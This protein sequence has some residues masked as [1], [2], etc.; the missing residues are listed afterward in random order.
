M[1]K[2]FAQLKWFFIIE[3]K[4]Y[5]SSVIILIS[6][7]IL[8]LIPPWLIGNIIDKVISEKYEKIEILIYIFSIVFVAL[9]IYILRCMWRIL[10]F[11]AAYKLSVKLRDKLYHSLSV[12]TPLFYLKNN[13]GNLI[14]LATNDIDR[15][16]FAAGE[17]FL[18]LVDSCVISCGVLV[19][20]IFNV[21]LI[22]TVISLLPMPIM[23]MI[24]KRDGDLLHKYFNLAQISFSTLNNQ[25]QENLNNIRMIKSFGIEYYQEKVFS[26]ILRELNRKNMQV[27]KIDARFDP[28][29]YL[30]IGLS[31]L[32][33]V[34]LGSILVL[35]NTISIGQLTSFI[36]YLGLMVWPMLALAWMFNIV[37]RGQAAYNRIYKM[38]NK[39]SNIKDGYQKLPKR[40]KGIL[41]V[42][43]DKFIYPGK[44]SIA[45]SNINFKLIPGDIIGI[46]GPT[47]S[48]KST[49]FSLILRN[50]ILNKGKIT[51]NNISLDNLIIDQWRSKLAVVHQTPFL[52]S[53]S[54]AN[55]ISMGFPE[56]NI[57]QI[58]EAANLA[59][60]H[61]DIKKF[62]EGY[63]TNI[64]ER[65]VILS[66]GQKQ[67]LAI[68]R[69]LMLKNSDILIIDD[70]LSSLDIETE[71]NIISNISNWSKNKSVIISSHRLSTLEKANEIL[72]INKGTIIQRGSHKKLIKEDGWY[73]T[74][75]SY[76]KINFK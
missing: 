48:G 11:G 24:I 70:A 13:T 39:I 17:G 35:N 47:G 21:S 52:F 55:N 1:L 44:N 50:F 27:A 58:K 57:F 41:D 75:Y 2:F 67:R 10:L 61:D 20:M 15:V 4:K 66:G 25:I 71:N 69:A 5:L 49:I 26:N 68:A 51:F 18:T 30:T 12:Q 3:W 63:N 38:I 60:I 22:L 33:T 14:T 53:D 19:V 31:N 28:I 8:Q 62:P 36:M 23:V 9:I 74:V 37:E 72:V 6:I 42:K 43:I 34:I 76:Q 29:I 45:L 54:I 64:G 56:A 7:S 73:K 40:I 16:V 46:C 59:C 32:I 65:G